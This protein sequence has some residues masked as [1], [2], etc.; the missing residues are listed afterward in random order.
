MQNFETEIRKDMDGS[1][2]WLQ[3]VTSDN[4]GLGTC[5]GK[6]TVLM[7]DRMFYMLK[8]LLMNLF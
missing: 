6:W 3:L 4:V 8:T 5:A 1:A 2:V 7:A